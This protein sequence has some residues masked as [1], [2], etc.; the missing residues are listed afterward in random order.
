MAK[1][2]KHSRANIVSGTLY[3][4]EN[5]AG[6]FE[7]SARENGERAAS[8]ARQARYRASVI[9]SLSARSSVVL[10]ARPV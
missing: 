3:R 5:V 6:I 7:P 2:K 1:R 4:L 9:I 10:L 8:R